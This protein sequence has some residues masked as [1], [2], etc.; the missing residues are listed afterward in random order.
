MVSPETIPKYWDTGDP[1]IVGVVVIIS[2]VIIF[3]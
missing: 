1:S 3:F 2:L